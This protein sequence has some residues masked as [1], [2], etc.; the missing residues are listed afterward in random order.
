MSFYLFQLTIPTPIKLKSRHQL[1]FEIYVML[2]GIEVK[3]FQVL[4]LCI[5]GCKQNQLMQLRYKNGDQFFWVAC[6]GSL[7]W[8]TE[9]TTK[10]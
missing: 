5:Y 2:D 3:P 6:P 8:K 4:L 7:V 10:S 9:Y 1:M